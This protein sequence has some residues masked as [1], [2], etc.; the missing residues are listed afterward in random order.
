M[1]AVVVAAHACVYVCV[2]VCVCVCVDE[3]MRVL[4]IDEKQL[5]LNDPVFQE[6]S[7]FPKETFSKYSS[8]GGRLITWC[9][10]EYGE[11]LVYHFLARL[12]N[13]KESR[14]YLVKA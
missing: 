5:N 7:Y 14:S 11:K 10:V 1:V 3:W 2:C 4:L 12:L 13:A 9:A 6:L 8:R